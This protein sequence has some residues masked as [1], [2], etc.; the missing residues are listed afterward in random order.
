MSA[1]VGLLNESLTEAI[2]SFYKLRK[3][4]LALEGVMENERKFLSKRSTTSVNSAGFNQSLKG[5]SLRSTSG[6]VRSKMAPGLQKSTSTSA[7]ASTTSLRQ[8]GSSNPIP[9]IVTTPAAKKEDDD[10]DEFHFEDAEEDHKGSATPAGYMGHLNTPGAADVLGTDTS[11][12]SDHPIDA[13]ILAGS[14]FCFGMLLL[15]LSF[16]PPT[17]A[18]LL[19]I[20]GFKGDRERGMQ[21]LWKAT[22]F[23]DIHGAMAGVV[24]MGYLNGFSSICDIIVSTGEGSYPKERCKALLRIMREVRRDYIRGD[25][26]EH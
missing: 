21:M 23:H 2:K 6:S 8:S 19:K 26:R 4:Y 13:F 1:V 7:A 12:I 14:N 22:Q 25:R 16:V 9:Q 5:G 17:F 3:A 20:V 11:S 24:L 10:D 18:P 15:L